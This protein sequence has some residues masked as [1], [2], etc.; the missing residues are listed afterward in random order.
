M[1]L[2]SILSKDF[3]ADF[4]KTLPVV[5]HLEAFSI[6]AS[7]V[8]DGLS[9]KGVFSGSDLDELKKLKI[10]MEQLLPLAEGKDHS[11]LVADIAESMKITLDDQK[12]IFTF[13]ISGSTLGRMMNKYDDFI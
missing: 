2:A 1:R 11:G 8:N 9:V 3:T 4:G 5:S 7:R 13:D 12:L 10:L 6:N